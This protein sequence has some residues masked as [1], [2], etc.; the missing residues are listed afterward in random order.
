VQRAIAFL[1]KSALTANPLLTPSG[2]HPTQTLRGTAGWVDALS[3]DWL[4]SPR[5]SRGGGV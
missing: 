1:A 5:R 4:V 3:R 2:L